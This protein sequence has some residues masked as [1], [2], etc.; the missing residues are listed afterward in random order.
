MLETMR[1]KAASWV[2]KILFLFLILSFAVWGVG[3][4]FRGRGTPQTVA[5][6]GGT[7][8][9]SQELSEQFR[10]LMNSMRSRLGD[11][12]D[13]QKAVQLGLLDQTLDQIIN[14]QLLLLNAQHLGL[15]ISDDLIRTT[16][17]SAPEFH[18]V[19][20]TF[21]PMRFRE[22]LVQ[23]GFPSEGAYVTRL[24][25]DM[26]RHQVTS[27]VTDG[28]APPKQLV[29]LLFSY[30]NEH[31]VADVVAVPLG[32]PK[33][34]A[35]P[36]PSTI[37]AFYKK[38][39]GMFTAPEYRQIT[40]I[41]L[42]PVERAAG[43]KVP[44]Q[45]LKEEYQ[46]RLPS[47]SVPERRDLEQLLFQDEAAAQKVYAA[48]KGG[49]SFAKAA[50]DVAKKEPTALGKM[51]KGELPAS[52]ASVAFSLPKDGVSPPTKSPLGWHVVHVI[53]ID[54]GKTPSF[55]EVKQRIHDDLARDMAVDQLSRL[56]NQLDDALAGGA[57][58]EE[59]ASKI[60]ARLVKVDAV[61]AHGLGRNGKP[62]AGAPKDPKFLNVAFSS[63]QGEVSTIEETRDGGFFVLRVDKI[64][65]P[66][67]R[68]LDEVRS[69]AIAAWKARELRD[70]ARKEATALRDAAKG[71]GSL[72]KAAGKQGLKV[73]T[74]KPFTRFI[75]EPSSPVPDALAT[76][77][78]RLKPG[79]LAM[80]ESDNG[81]VVGE[82]K[83]ITPA[84][85]AQNKD[86]IKTI[87]DQLRTAVGQDLFGQ[88]VSALKQRYTVKI[89]HEAV[90]S[91][92]ST[93]G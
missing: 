53:G 57:T 66:A 82:L 69:Q 36:D 8:I 39:P 79:G 4:M 13:T 63:P 83:S 90:D 9:P 47:L 21:D 59:A 38:N 41:Y 42:D 24:R 81:Y 46:S 3:D 19:G 84:D 6:V 77:L 33:S 25:R 1:S 61:D 26:L 85:P 88:Y 62:V 71:A 91:I 80:V 14:G 37:E 56:T 12:F 93:G 68:P 5:E 75:R 86:E 23:Q 78:F 15:T 65:P 27:A 30:R 50:K 64:V 32:D 48:I 40:A 70:R 20:N 2:V 72:T 7:E 17:R 74:S 73:V 16:I 31:R 11:S 76:E 51:T 29:D 18:G 92:V 35:N 52:L 22:F 43:I 58:L 49:M 45:R 10:Q 44:E 54:P 67:V 55:D 87:Q 89:N 34:L 28:A 60:G